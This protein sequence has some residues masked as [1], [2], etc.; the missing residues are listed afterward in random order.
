MG[1]YRIAGLT[2]EMEPQYPTLRK[3]AEA[4]RAEAEP[5]YDLSLRMTDEYLKQRQAEYPHLSLE[6]C[7]Y[8]WAGSAFYHRLI[9]FEGLLLHASGVVYENRAYLFSA[10]SGTGKSTHTTQW[11][12]LFGKDK[13]FII[14]DDKPALRLE[15][16]R[17]TV[18]G[19]PFSGKSD[20][21][22]N[23]GVPLGGICFLERSP[24]NWIRRMDPA[25]VMGPLFS[26]TIRPAQIAQMD[27]LLKVVDRLLTVEKIYAMGCNISTDAA[28]VAYEGMRE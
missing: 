28:R 17:F 27:K 21:S 5:P 11:Q 18:Y 20:K 26:Q 12:K 23:V 10:N 1:V 13:T 15:N 7:E 8:I 14:N 2:M 16:G 4:Y 24:D 22:V 9:D 3:Q 19:T 6:Q 25:E